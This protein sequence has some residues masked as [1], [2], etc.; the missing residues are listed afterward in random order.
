MDTLHEDTHVMLQIQLHDTY[1]DTY[2]LARSSLVST[3]AWD[4]TWS[5][6]SRGTLLSLSSIKSMLA[7][8]GVRWEGRGEVQPMR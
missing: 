8:K 1:G 4:T 6:L 2:T 7:L 5:L 3:G